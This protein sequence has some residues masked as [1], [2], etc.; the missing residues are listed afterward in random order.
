M[1][2]METDYET[3]EQSH[4]G[5]ASERLMS[6]LKSLA[7]DAE[8]LLKATAS[9][10]TDKAREARSRLQSALERA[11]S[12]Y[13]DVQDQ[14][15]AAAKAAAGKADSVIRDYPYQTLGIAIGVGLLI[16]VLVGRS[17]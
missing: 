4:M 6:D 3:M 16:G 5:D 13:H 17:K 14:T 1:E 10:V 11:K 2:I 12:S 7:E 9:D 15:M 8:M